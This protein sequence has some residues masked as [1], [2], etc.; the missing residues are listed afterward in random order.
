MA[1]DK[2]VSE[3]GIDAGTVTN[4]IVNWTNEVGIPTAAALRIERRNSKGLL[5]VFESVQEDCVSQEFCPVRWQTMK[6][7]D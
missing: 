7:A 1:R 4:I 5:R 3:I 2:T 6:L